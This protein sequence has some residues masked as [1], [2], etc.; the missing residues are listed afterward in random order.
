VS[1]VDANSVVVATGL[2]ALW[3]GLTN[4]MLKYLKPSMRPWLV[5]AGAVLVAAGAYGLARARRAP[6][7][8]VEADH[9]EH[10]HRQGVGWLL[11]VPL[12]VMLVLGQQ[13]LGAFAASRS[14]TRGLPPYSFDIRAYA[15]QQNTSTPELQLVDVYLGAVQRGNREYLASHSVRLRGFATPD[16]SL[17]P[18]GF[19]LT[20]FLVSCCAADAT[21]IRLG[22]IGGPH[23]P[24]PE[25]WVEVT[26]RLDPSFTPPSGTAPSTAPPRS[27]LR[28]Q[29]TK[30]ISEPAEPYETLR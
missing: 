8:V 12:L 2:L 11:V 21:P 29:T 13:A 1:P 6:D 7:P 20:R 10:H 19:V 17:G 9:S 28:V 30:G 25:S 4:A 23:T 3:M 18:H 16:P 15:D 24:K 22:M 27:T 14:S 26:A 5:L